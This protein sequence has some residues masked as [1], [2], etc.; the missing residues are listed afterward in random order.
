MHIRIYKRGLGILKPRSKDHFEADPFEHENFNVADSDEEDQEEQ[1]EHL[2]YSETSEDF[3]QN[4]PTGEGTCP[5]CK[6]TLKRLRDHIR[7]THMPA[8]CDLCD[9]IFNTKRAMKSH[10][11]RQHSNEEQALGDNQDQQTEAEN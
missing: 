5:L 4:F 1:P 7:W 9:S 6:K 2:E 8:K 3:F 11:K 10:Q